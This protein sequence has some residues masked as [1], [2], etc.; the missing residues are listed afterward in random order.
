[1]LTLCASIAVPVLLYI[2]ENWIKSYK[3][4]CKTQAEE[5]KVL[6]SVSIGPFIYLLWWDETMSLRTAA[7]NG[8]IV[9]PRV[10]YEHGEPW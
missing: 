9:D 6:R 1:V 5:M 8:P 2:R 10:I 7:T 3:S 4:V